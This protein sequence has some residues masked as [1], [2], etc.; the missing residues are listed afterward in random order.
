M[1]FGISGLEN[2]ASGN[3][4]LCG[5][6]ITNMPIRKRS[7]LGM[8]HI[9][10][11]RHKHG[12]VLDYTLEDNIVLWWSLPLPPR[13]PVLPRQRAF[14]TIREADDLHRIITGL[15]VIFSPNAQECP[16]RRALLLVLD[17]RSR[18]RSDFRRRQNSYSTKSMVVTSNI[19]FSVSRISGMTVNAIKD[20]VVKGSA[21]GDTPMLL[22]CSTILPISF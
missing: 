19:P 6:D 9:P 15:F 10:E 3:V 18:F 12:L 2:V 22:A 14:P 5:T 4:K 13:S 20:R 11:D 17:I 16:V 8:S 21:P 7:L 1:V